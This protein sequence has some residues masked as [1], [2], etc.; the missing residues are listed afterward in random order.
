MIT[1]QDLINAGYRNFTEGYKLRQ[2]D[3][4]FQKDIKENGIKKYFINLYRV[5]IVKLV[6]GTWGLRTG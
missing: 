1:E 4:L 2:E 3:A 5:G 6:I